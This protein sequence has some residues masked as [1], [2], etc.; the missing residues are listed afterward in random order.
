MAEIQMPKGALARERWR[1]IL[2]RIEAHERRLDALE[3]GEVYVPDS[4]GK[5]EKESDESDEPDTSG[6]GET[7]KAELVARAAKLEVGAPSTL[8]RWGEDRLR[9]EIEKAES[10]KE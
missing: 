2:A 6:G 9:A 8:E 7:T 4:N 3:R 10:A 1:G 5:P